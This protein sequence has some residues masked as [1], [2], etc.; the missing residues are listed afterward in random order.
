MFLYKFRYFRNAK[1]Y[2]QQNKN[3]H[4]IN[5]QLLVSAKSFKHTQEVCER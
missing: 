2:F 3:Q 5:F 4:K 1:V